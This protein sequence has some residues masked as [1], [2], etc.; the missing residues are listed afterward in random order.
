MP[1]YKKVAFRRKDDPECVVRQNCLTTMVHSYTTERLLTKF[2]KNPDEWEIVPNAT[3]VLM[4]MD[5]PRKGMKVTS[6]QRPSI[7]GESEAI[8]GEEDARTRVAILSMGGF[9][10][11]L[12]KLNMARQLRPKLERELGPIQLTWVGRQRY[13]IFDSFDFIDR[14]EIR[15]PYEHVSKLSPIIIE[16][17]DLT[18]DTRYIAKFLKS[19][20][21]WDVDPLEGF[22]S[23]VFVADVL[24]QSIP[25]A[26][27]YEDDG[28]YL[29]WY[30]DQITVSGRE[31]KTL[32]A[33]PRPY[34]IVANGNDPTFTGRL[35][36]AM[37]PSTIYDF[38]DRLSHEGINTIQV[39]VEG[40]EFIQAPGAISFIGKT[41]MASLIH[42]IRGSVGVLACEGG[43]AHLASQLDVPTVVLFG[44]TD[45]K[46]WGYPNNLNLVAE[47]VDCP[48]RPCWFREDN[49][50]WHINCAA[51]EQGLFDIVRGYPRCMAA[52]KG[53]DV[54]E[55]FLEHLTSKDKY[56]TRLVDKSA[57]TR[58]N[59]M[60]SIV[61]RLFRA[62]SKYPKAAVSEFRHCHLVTPGVYIGG[63]KSARRVS[64]FE[65]LDI[66]AVLNLTGDTWADY[67]PDIEYVQI[68]M[69]D[70]VGNEDDVLLEA[71]YQLSRMVSSTKGNVLVHCHA[72]VSRSSTIVAMYMVTNGVSD[73]FNS[74]ISEI[75]KTRTIVE[76]CEALDRQAKR[77]LNES[78]T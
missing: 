20:Q 13:D 50:N 72:G 21:R 66:T 25:S 59:V 56:A 12:V 74:A 2:G 23:D 48:L 68:P 29:K 69:I 10:D 7:Y 1:L 33:L 24:A 63:C 67:G 34:V 27:S 3:Q 44:A 36:K 46:F 30:L 70:G 38:S 5:K 65:K 8:E 51:H 55:S 60:Q 42:L 15:G 64:D 11:D 77:L 52:F 57:K 19:G 9:G 31:N 41:S 40:V 28:K 26:Y 78:S 43:V 54:A 53:V 45:P 6:Q 4:P 22:D 16:K 47:E 17:H 71:S 39:G 62:M 18:I 14:W 32:A 75:R 61:P 76:P 58:G 73:D 37:A 49:Y 35:V